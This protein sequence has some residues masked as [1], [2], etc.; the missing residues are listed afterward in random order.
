MKH[1]ENTR[2]GGWCTALRH[3]C[4]AVGRAVAAF[5][6]LL[7]VAGGPAAAP[8]AMAPTD[9]TAIGPVNYAV[10]VDESGSI[11]PQ[12]M[13]DERAAA[14]RIALGDVSAASTVSVYGF[15]DAES[16]GESPVD[17]VCPA[18]KLDTAGRD[19]IGG[20]VGRLTKRAQ[21]KGAGTDFPNA[22]RQGVADL[23]KGTDPGVPRV[24]FILTDG[25][26][27]V[28]DSPAYGDPAHRQAEGQRQL[29]LALKEAA[30][31]NVQIW[32]LGFGS[33]IDMNT[34]R[35]MAGSGFQ[36]GCVSLPDAKP[37]AQ[38]VPDS[39]AV[40]GALQTAFAAAHC[41]RDD[42]GTSGHP[43]TTLS[44]RIS[45]LATV[46]SIVVAKGDPQVTATYTDPNGH[47]VPG[48]GSFDG[49]RFELAGTGQPVEALRITDPLPGVWKVHLEA[50]QGHR[51]Q[52]ASVSVLWHGELRSS[53]T[54]D[55]PSPHAGDKA[56]VTLR[57][58]TRQGYEITDPRDYQGLTVSAQLT[59][60]GFS[61]VPLRL[62][63]DGRAPDARAGDGAF[64]GDVTIP[65]TASG[66]LKV[67][68]TLTAV[69]LTADADRSEGGLVAPAVL[70]VTATLTIPGGSQ[71]HPGGRITGTLAVHNGDSRPHTLSLV[72]QDLDDGILTVSPQRLTAAPGDA[73]VRKVTLTVAS[74]SALG[75]R[76]SGGTLRLGGKITAQDASD[77]DRVLA[78]TPLSLTVTPP[79][80]FWQSYRW[81]LIGGAALLALVAV[82]LVNRHRIRIIQTNAAGLSLQ[83]VSDEGQIVNEHLARSGRKGWYEFD[84]AEPG[85]THPRIVRR[86]GGPYRVQRSPDGGAV[87]RRRGAGQAH[88]PL[89][90]QATLSHGLSLALGAGS[91]PKPGPGGLG[92]VP[93][94]TATPQDGESGY[95][96]YL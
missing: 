53:I 14:S 90:G 10:A 19:Q 46:G 49:S 68:G 37:R 1:S 33:D 77:R 50:P 78:D 34:L 41:L 45:P 5:G 25:Q 84:V 27:D 75:R 82:G 39:A 6:F 11:Q 69:G 40:G 8:A 43:P 55:P 93:E 7:A 70:L 59:G 71:V 21:D 88:L 31:A 86:P 32:P 83:L 57:L 35:Q 28:S 30:D 60:D 12:E 4:A 72:V 54:L 3:A 2:I 58:Q 89:G 51:D 24:L 87:L 65:T 16:A 81:E 52:L 61:P 62:A 48:N 74:R 47:Q 79:P 92:P 94:P 20:C 80:G 56:V 42:T 66:R 17:P 22:I 23:S 95:H 15:A 9:A 18:T 85:G 67:S 96:D 44:V 63:D 13:A 29:G 76:L 64:T 91:R 38:A 36:D 26:L 73:P